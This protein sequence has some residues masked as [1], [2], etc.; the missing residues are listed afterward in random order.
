MAVVYDGLDPIPHVN[1]AARENPGSN[2]SFSI[3]VENREKAY[4]DDDGRLIHGAAWDD[5][6]GP[7]SMATAGLSAPTTEAFGDTGYPGVFFRHD[8]DDEVYWTLQTSH[9]W[10]RTTSLYFHLHIVPMA[11]PVSAQVIRFDGAY[12]WAHYGQIVPANAAWTAITAVSHTV[13]PGDLRVPAIVALVTIPSGTALESDIL[14]IRV[15]RPG[16]ADATDTYTTSKP[17]SGTA[18]ANVCILYGDAH[19]QVVKAGTATEIPS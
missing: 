13:N 4:F 11:D 6:I 9:R 5:L 15:R 1:T 8:Q 16:S 17:G 12:A 2:K 14:M 10:D 19:Y 3:R 18:A 7:I